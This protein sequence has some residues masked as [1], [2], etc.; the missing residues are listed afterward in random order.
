MNITD[1]DNKIINGAREAGDNDIYA[2][3][4]KWEK[5]FFNDM[6]A[7]GIE[8]PDQ[9]T[10][11]TEFMEEINEFI[12]TLIEKGYAYRTDDGSVYFDVQK[13]QEDGY[14]RLEILKQNQQTCL[15]LQTYPRLEPLASN[16][17][18]QNQDVNQIEVKKFHKDF[19]LWKAVKEGEPS[20]DSPFGKGRPGWHIECSAMIQKAFQGEKTI[21]IHSG[22]LDLKFPHH[23]NEICQSCAHNG[24]KNVQFNLKNLTVSGSTTS[25]T[26]APFTSMSVRCQGPKKITQ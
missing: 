20:W 22:G 1:V 8:M 16:S 12:S 2:Y 11:V 10:R 4:R 24:V 9:I 13:Y 3:S 21:D 5:S 18:M 15:I 7:L 14:V 25:S 23:D 17:E 26:T 6:K 19:A